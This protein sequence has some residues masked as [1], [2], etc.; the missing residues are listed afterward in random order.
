MHIRRIS[1]PW[2]VC[3]H[4]VHTACDVKTSARLVIY[5]HIHMSL[6][7][8]FENASSL[9]NL[10]SNPFEYCY[11][12]SRIVLYVNLL[13]KFRDQRVDWILFFD[14][15]RVVIEL[16]FV[17]SSFVSFSKTCDETPLVV[18]KTQKAIEYHGHKTCE[19]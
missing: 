6:P 16:N 2:A 9:A 1:L 19:I 15:F 10:S 14:S 3:Q 8:R 5:H 13:V 17:P 4:K 18:V 12:V 7:I 11:V